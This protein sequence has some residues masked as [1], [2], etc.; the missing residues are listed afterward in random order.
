MVDNNRIQESESRQPSAVTWEVLQRLKQDQI[1]EEKP[2]KYSESGDKSLE[3][4]LRSMM[5]LVRQE[6]FHL[7]RKKLIRHHQVTDD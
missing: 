6:Y 7:E 2:V 1:Q 5:Q 4:L 3:L